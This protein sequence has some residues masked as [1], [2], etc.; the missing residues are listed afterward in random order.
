MP[1]ENT[2]VIVVTGATKGIG[3]AIVERF[4]SEGLD[5]AVCARNSAELDELK[6]LL[7]DKHGV[8]I[9]AIQA[10]LSVRADIERFVNAVTRTGS[11][12]KVLVN[13]AGRFVPGQL[14]S[15]PDGT[16]ETMIETNLYSAYYVT[17][18]LIGAMIA[19]KEGH[20][21]NIS[22]IAALAAYP[23]GGSYAVSKYALTGFS[24]CLRE[25][26]KAFGIKVTNV[27]PGATYTESWKG[28]SLPE[29]RFASAADIAEIVWAT[30]RLSSAT[31]VEDIVVRPQLGD[32]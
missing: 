24:R 18:G 30:S 14:H 29:D 1:G 27:M 19:R 17:R 21:F 4:A 23:N 12:V 26:V 2:P 22:S 9:H 15:E 16:L 7:Q 32:L 31:V 6:A 11:P 28:T 13:N 8:R 5:A 25:E 20:I 3:R 10:D